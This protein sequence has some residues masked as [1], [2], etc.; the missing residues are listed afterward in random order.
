MPLVVV[1]I[2]KHHDMS[3]ESP[4]LPATEG[5]PLLDYLAKIMPYLYEYSREKLNEGNF[6]CP[7]FHYGVIGAVYHFDPRKEIVEAYGRVSGKN[8]INTPITKKETSIIGGKKVHRLFWDEGLTCMKRQAGRLIPAPKRM[9]L[10]EFK[11]D[12]MGNRLPV[13]IGFDLDGLCEIGE[14]VPSRRIIE[15][16]LDR[17][18]KVL[19]C[20]YSP[21]FAC[22]ARSQTP[23]RYVPLE[24]VNSLQ[25][26]AL[27]LIGK[28][29]IRGMIP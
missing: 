6:S 20:I 24:I 12:L 27:N 21:S 8:L 18:K 2:D 15:E 13:A 3:D 17:S 16:R 25:E 7:A 23:R 29:Y 26:A 28:I 14:N 22:I 19:E 11:K 10:D 5:R 4:V 9:S 1:R